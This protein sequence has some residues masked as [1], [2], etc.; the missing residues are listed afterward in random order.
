MCAALASVMAVQGG[1]ETS[2]VANTLVRV[3]ASAMS[4]RRP[5]IAATAT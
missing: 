4:R 5:S 1:N 3:L 2:E